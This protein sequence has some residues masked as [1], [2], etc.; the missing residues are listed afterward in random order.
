MEIEQIKEY[1]V[2]KDFEKAVY[3]KNK[4]TN[5]PEGDQKI[6]VHFVFDDKHCGK[7]K[8]R[9]VADGHL[10]KEPM[11]TVYSG[12]VSIRNLRLAMFLAELNNLEL[13][14]ADFGNA[15]LQALTRE[16][17]YIVGG[18][19][20]EEL[21]GH[22]LVMYKALYGT[23]S[24]GA[25]WHDKFF[26]ILHDM[27]FKPS[28]AD[29]DIW[30]K[31]SKDGSHYEYIAVYV[32]DLAICMKD[33]KSFFVTHSKK[34]TNSNGREVV[35]SII[36]LDVE[37]LEM[38]MELLLHIQENM[39]RKYLSLMK[40]PLE[41]NQRRPRHPCWEEITQRVTYL[42]FVTRTRPSNIRQLLDN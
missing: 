41:K 18:P 13:W 5:E 26:D 16:K 40:K 20:F 4:I 11:E 15:Y 23:R 12:V 8:A 29:P 25:C 37:T 14:G 27:G 31:S 39:L 28:K 32:D 21:Q 35:Q 34:N 24:G 22:V 30:M 42:I 1:Q 7:F 6:R 33:P 3:E 38:K 9:L 36:T 10:N 19:E 17:L 2:F